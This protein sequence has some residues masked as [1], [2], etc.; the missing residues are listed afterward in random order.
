MRYT[1]RQLAVFL[2]VARLGSVSRAARELAM[3][4][5][6]ASGSLADLDRQFDVRLFDRAGKRVQ[7]SDLGGSLR[8]PGGR[9]FEMQLDMDAEQRHAQHADGVWSRTRVPPPRQTTRRRREGCAFYGVRIWVHTPS[10]RGA[11][12]RNPSQG[13]SFC[14]SDTP[15]TKDVTHHRPA[16]DRAAKRPSGQ[17]ASSGQ[18]SGGSSQS[19]AGMTA[20]R[21]DGLIIGWVR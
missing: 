17:T 18:R 20:T 4:Q 16:G 3:S 2:A 19:S 13:R 9:A 7:L 8:A 10:V 15:R 21:P 5:S 6:A 14:T 11:T 12:A 1:L